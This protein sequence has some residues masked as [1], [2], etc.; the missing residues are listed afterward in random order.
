MPLEP[1]IVFAAMPP[2]QQRH[3][4]EIAGQI[5]D[6]M[7]RD[8][9]STGEFKRMLDTNPVVRHC[10]LVCQGKSQKTAAQSQ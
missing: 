6:Q 2:E 9:V 10:V 4:S 7:R 3:I 5:T 8:G 1:E